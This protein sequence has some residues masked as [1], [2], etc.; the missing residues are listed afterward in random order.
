MF[1]IV[2]HRLL[3]H[4]RYIMFGTTAIILF[5]DNCTPPL[6]WNVCIHRYL[7]LIDN[8]IYS[9]KWRKNLVFF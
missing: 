2:S 8:A 6:T 9:F 4:V 1:K 7:E 3:I 5:Y